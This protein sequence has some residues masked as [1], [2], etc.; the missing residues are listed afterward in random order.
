M[1]HDGT[2]EKNFGRW[3]DANNRNADDAA[4]GMLSSIRSA[5]SAPK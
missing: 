5:T 1:I 3:V 2:H 4:V